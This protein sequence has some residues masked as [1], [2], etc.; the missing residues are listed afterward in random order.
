MTTRPNAVNA[1]KE[2][3]RKKRGGQPGNTNAVK[4][5][6]T[7]FSSAQ[8]RT[9]GCAASTASTPKTSPLPNAGACKS[10]KGLSSGMR[11]PCCVCSSG[12]QAEAD[13]NR[14]SAVPHTSVY[15]QEQIQ[16]S[17]GVALTES[18]QAEADS[19]RISLQSP[20]QVGVP[21]KWLCGQA[22]R[23]QVASAMCRTNDC[24]A[25]HGFYTKNFSLAERKGLHSKS[26]LRASRQGDRPRG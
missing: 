25:K 2:P 19:I 6:R 1:A 8:C 17:Q 9:H 26:A 20:R 23:L 5:K 12:G 15:G 7:Q 21:H 16:A 10:P 18:A 13:T 11:S 4:L 14:L 24:A 3:G 22:E